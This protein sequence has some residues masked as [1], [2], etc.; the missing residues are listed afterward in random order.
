MVV[1]SQRSESTLRNEVSVGVGATFRSSI[2]RKESLQIQLLMPHS[3]AARAG[4]DLDAVA[5]FS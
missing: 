3:A 5:Q 2:G 1:K 4:R